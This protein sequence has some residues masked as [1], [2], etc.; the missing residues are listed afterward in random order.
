MDFALHYV[1]TR[2]SEKSALN[3][4]YSKSFARK[5]SHE[6]LK[7]PDIKEKIAHFEDIYYR[8]QFKRLALKSIKELE[9]I[10]SDSESRGPQLQAIKYTLEQAGAQPTGN[11]SGTIEIKVSLPDDL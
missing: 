2:N 3:A 9:N 10:I 7:N 1:Q 5:R 4:G 6:L 8:E 11:G